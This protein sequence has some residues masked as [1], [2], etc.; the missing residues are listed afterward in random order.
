MNKKGDFDPFFFTYLSF[1]FLIGIA[2]IL[3]IIQQGMHSSQVS[4]L[5]GR[6]FDMY[7]FN[8]KLTILKDEYKENLNPFLFHHHIRALCENV[9]TGEKEVLT[10]E[11]SS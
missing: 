1:T 10:T 9:L 2:V 11:N 4:E 5:D 8:S 6:C 3:A 7:S